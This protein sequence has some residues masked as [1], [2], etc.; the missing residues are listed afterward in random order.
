M[1]ANEQCPILTQYF[2]SSLLFL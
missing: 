2:K 1:G